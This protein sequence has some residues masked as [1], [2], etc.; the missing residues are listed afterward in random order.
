[1]TALVFRAGLGALSGCNGLHQVRLPPFL[2]WT[3]LHTETHA[4]GDQGDPLPCSRITDRY[5]AVIKD[6]SLKS[7]T[8]RLARLD[9]IV[10]G[11]TRYV[12][13]AVWKAR[14][15]E[16]ARAHEAYLESLRDVEFIEDQFSEISKGR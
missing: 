1:M 8:R 11:Y 4:T 5:S 10:V 2:R 6:E 15:S 13:E 3:V 14:G 12:S 9:S 7:L 16:D